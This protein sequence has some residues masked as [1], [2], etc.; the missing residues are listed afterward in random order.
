MRIEDRESLSGERSSITYVDSY[1][2]QGRSHC[3]RADDHPPPCPATPQFCVTS[4]VYHGLAIGI[5]CVNEDFK[6]TYDVI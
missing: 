1:M 5:S 3:H 6:S 4:T 2:T